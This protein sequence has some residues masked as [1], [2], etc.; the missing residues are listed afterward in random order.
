MSKLKEVLPGLAD[1]QHSGQKSWKWLRFWVPAEGET[2][3]TGRTVFICALVGIVVGLMA[4]WF[5]SMIE[6]VKV[7]AMESFAHHHPPSAD[8]ELAIAH[9]LDIQ[10]TL[11][12]RMWGGGEV[13]G[14]Q[15]PALGEIFAGFIRFLLPG[16][17]ALLA[18][19]V[20]RR[21]A[22]SAGGH[23]TDTV[24]G[25]YHHSGT[26]LPIAV[27]PV[28]VIASS[29]VIGTGGSAGAEGPITQ[30]GAVCG[31]TVARLLRLSPYERRILLAAGMAA[32]I[33]AIFRSPMAGALFAA[34]I[35]YRGFD[36]EGDVLIPSM[37]ASTVS[38]MTFACVFGWEPVF[39]TPQ[40]F[41]D[42]PIKFLCYTLLAFI[43]AA[44]VRFS[45]MFFRQTEIV[46]RRLP[47]KPWAKPLVGGLMVG[48]IGLF[49]PQILSSGY[50]YIQQTL[51]G[52][53]A[54]L[55]SPYFGEH[56]ILLL[57]GL[58]VLKAIATAFSVG[59]GGAGGMLGPALFSG[60]MYGAGIGALFDWLFPELQICIAN[61]AMIGM[62]G[63][64]TAAVRTPLAAILMV[65]E[66]TGNH[67][68]LL[69]AMWVCGLSF[70]L[71]PGWT[72]YRSQV[73]D[74]DS[75]PAHQERHGSLKH[76]VAVRMQPGKRV[77]RS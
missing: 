63:Y 34:E 5:F 61:C 33:G 50:G 26:D 25:A 39:H 74:R 55:E 30:I 15:I 27:A 68:L 42:S 66:F 38:Y 60:A 71:T 37:V 72:L 16:L 18:C 69:P 17:G 64:L 23:G 24:I 3:Q 22:P 7:F 70:L 57:L 13:L 19:L 10:Y 58:G 73:R 51:Q 29:L 59:S 8:G 31:T 47:W 1:L 43:I 12:N 21:F 77:K 65:S 45:I 4:V 6:W 49:F 53:Q 52:N 11:L 48:A 56:I 62:A 20:A 2:L 14:M 76:D 40:E 35:F 67:N 28:K 41:F 54:V 46:F 32:G 75:S 36:L 9:A 44:M